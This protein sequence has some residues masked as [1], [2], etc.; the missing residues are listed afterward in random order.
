MLHQ[1]EV[2]DEHVAPDVDETWIQATHKKRCKQT[3]NRTGGT[4]GIDEISERKSLR[5]YS[6]NSCGVQF[7]DAHTVTPKPS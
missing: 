1:S 5:R 6:H 2:E 3:E 7:K 4:L